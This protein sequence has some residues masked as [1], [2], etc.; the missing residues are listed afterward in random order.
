[1][2]LGQTVRLHSGSD[3]PVDATVLAITG[4]G[5]MPT[6]Y[7]VLK[8]KDKDD[9]VHDD[10]VYHEDKGSKTKFWSLVEDKVKPPRKKSSK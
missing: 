10:V 1:M 6:C 7:K 4:N 3:A 2:L 8:L 5:P 9:K